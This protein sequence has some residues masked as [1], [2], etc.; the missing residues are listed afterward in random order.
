MKYGVQM[1]LFSDAF[2]EDS[3]GLVGKTKQL[4]FDGIEVLIGDPHGFPSKQLREALL[5][6]GMGINFA[7]CLGAETNTISSDE[8]TRMRGNAFLKSC[9]DI[10]YEVTGG[11]CTIGGPNY[12]GWCCLTGKSVT[13]QE[14]KWAVSNYRDVC[15]YAAKKGIP[16]RWRS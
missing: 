6:H 13:E 12:A 7:A 9:I 4:G 16:S 5:R 1:L 8:S 3:T 15:E 10:A 11:G 14:W 2:G